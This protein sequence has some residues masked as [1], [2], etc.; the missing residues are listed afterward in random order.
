M[1]LFFLAYI[2]E[3][4]YKYHMKYISI[5]EA[6]QKWGMSDRRIRYLCTAGRVDGAIKL[7]WTWTIPSDAPRPSDGRHMRKYRNTD[8]RPG[9]VDVD[10]LR[11]LQEHFHPDT[12][13]KESKAYQKIILRSFTSL[14]AIAGEK[15]SERDAKAV[16][17]GRIV[18]SLSL[19]TH[20]IMLNFRSLMLSLVDMKERWNLKDMKNIYVRLLQGIDDISSS[21]FRSGL[22]RFPARETMVSVADDMEGA[23]LLYETQWRHMHGLVSASLLYAEVL[24]IDPYEEYSGL[25]AY[26]I[27]AGELLRNG[28]LPPLFEP[29]SI[30][31]EKAAF[32]LA[33]KQGN[34]TL[35]TSFVERAVH[36]SYKEIENV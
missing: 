33:I 13:L 32:S 1:D 24:R 35:F 10:G 36:S 17:S 22:S 18:P 27:L 23:V 5:T 31:E 30:D 34:Y 25:F 6:A 20:L 9:T 4:D 2:P 11:K 16:Y 3:S 29:D 19:E 15:V 28:I 12:S 21:S 14:M 8:I 7:G 26:L